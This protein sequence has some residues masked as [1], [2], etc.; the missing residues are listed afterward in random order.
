MSPRAHFYVVAFALTVLFTPFGASIFDGK[1]RDSAYKLAN[2]RESLARIT[3]A[4]ETRIGKSSTTVSVTYE[5][6][7]N[8]GMT[9]TG[10][11]SISLDEWRENRGAKPLRVYFDPSAPAKNTLAQGIDDYAEERPLEMRVAVAAIVSSPFAIILAAIW[12]WVV[13]RRSRK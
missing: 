8:A 5:F 12:A 13:S 6:Q 4:K 9:Y 10:W 2:Y 11:G 7:V 3:K 1:Q